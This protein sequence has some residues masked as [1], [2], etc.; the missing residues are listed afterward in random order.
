V[1]DKKK[2]PICSPVFRK[3]E[4][5][6]TSGKLKKK[7]VYCRCGLYNFVKKEGES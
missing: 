2:R 3:K 7:K 4:K 5:K 6:N 1:R